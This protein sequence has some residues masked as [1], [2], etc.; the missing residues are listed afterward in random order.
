MPHE[1]VHRIDLMAGVGGVVV[2]VEGGE[3]EAEDAGG[4]VE[5][6]AVGLAGGGFGELLLRNAGVGGFLEHFVLGYRG[7]GKDA[8]PVQRGAA[9]GELGR[10][11]GLGTEHGGGGGHLLTNNFYSSTTRKCRSLLMI[12]AYNYINYIFVNYIR[13]NPLFIV[14]CLRR[15]YN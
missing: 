11:V 8:P 4:V 2:V 12:T 10:V 7:R 9:H 3:A 14:K 6:V 1:F 15:V 5:I 13:N